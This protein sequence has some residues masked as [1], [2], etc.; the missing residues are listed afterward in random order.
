MENSNGL[1]HLSECEIVD[2]AVELMEKVRVVSPLRYKTLRRQ[3][4][5][6][7]EVWGDDSYNGTVSASKGV[8][9]AISLL[10]PRGLGLPVNTDTFPGSEPE[11]KS[12]SEITLVERVNSLM[13]ETRL[14]AG[15]IAI[16]EVKEKAY[17]NHLLEHPNDAQG[18]SEAAAQAVSNFCSNNPGFASYGLFIRT[19]YF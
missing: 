1:V 4:N 7:L 12:H 14:D 9:A 16:R 17:Y 19:G 2:K 13:L 15:H 11:P 18:A 3:Y 10:Y 8:I 6:D 5:S